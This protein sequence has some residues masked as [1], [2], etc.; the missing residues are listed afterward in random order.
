MVYLKLELAFRLLGKKRKGSHEG[1]TPEMNAWDFING[2]IAMAKER[3][4]YKTAA[5]YLTAANSL[6]QFWGH[7][8]WAFADI[9]HDEM[10]SFQRWLVERGLCMNTI[11]CYMRS[12][13]TLYNR[14]VECGLAQDTHPFAKVFTGK[15]HTHKRSAQEEDV[16]RLRNLFIDEGS[17]LSLAR[18]I[19]LFSFYAMGMPFVDIAFL[20]KS[21]IKN[22]QFKYAR[23][24]TGQEIVVWIEPC[25]AEI[26]VKYANPDSAYVFP[27]ITEQDNT[28]AYKQ[29]QSQLRLYNHNLGILSQRINATQPLSSYVV[30]H[31]WASLAYK[32]DF[33]VKLIS[34]A[35]GHTNTTTTLI[36]I[37]SLFDPKLAD[38]NHHLLKKLDIESEM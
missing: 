33:D 26:M 17:S 11:S 31:T 25:M 10:A 8:E 12:L 34:K 37:K 5:N 6:S 23:H 18:D 20:R 1:I 3:H 38:A 2:E 27:I 22:G 14:A 16:H 28:L 36:Y 29:Y 4:S 32:H 30:R 7:K 13:R 9:I 35:L 19:F 21:Q 15:Q 24:K